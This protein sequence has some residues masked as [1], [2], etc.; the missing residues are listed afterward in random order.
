MSSKS[1][2]ADQGGL[3]TVAGLFA[4]IGG[5]ELGLAESG[6]RTVLLCENDEAACAVLRQR[7]PGARLSHD[8]RALQ[9]LPRGV[10]MVTAGFPCQ[11]LSQA[12]R[13]KGIGGVRSSLVWQVFR[14][15]E[16][17][18]VPWLLL[19]N[20]PFM[21][22]LQRGRAM[23]Q[24]TDELR[25]L[26]Y[27]WAYR[28]VDAMAF[29]L[30]QRRR[31]VYLLACR[32]A[33]PAAILL[34]DQGASPIERTWR[35]GLAAGFYW[36]EGN[37]GVGWAIDALPPLKGGSGLGIHSPPSVLLPNGRVVKPDIRDAERLQGFPS[38]WTEPA[39]AVRPSLRW[40][41]VGNAVNVRVAAWIGR[42]IAAAIVCQPVLGARVARGRWPD[43]ACDLGDG[44]VAVASGPWPGRREPASLIDFLVHPTID[45]SAK[46]TA[47]FVARAERAQA[48]GKLRFPAGFLAALRKHLVSQTPT[49]NRTKEAITAIAAP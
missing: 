23:C 9:Q 17:R 45:L 18:R 12:G 42:R 1:T 39:N 32:D 49:A 43:A 35:L 3:R 37:R 8:V 6:H 14:L 31:R 21:L 25:A 33:D 47:G 24:I 2:K 30:P 46:A 7:F 38:N 48:L 29:G 15:L 40:R 11:D 22:H 4:G 13:T 19:E 34:G 20:V 27:R 16:E 36:T 5:L 26:G 10:D 28:V 41:L 44:P